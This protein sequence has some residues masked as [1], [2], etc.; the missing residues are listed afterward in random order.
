M[1]RRP[2]V[3]V[4]WEHNL[5]FREGRGFTWL[6]TRPPPQGEWSSQSFPANVSVGGAQEKDGSVQ[7]AAFWAKATAQSKFRDSQPL[8]PHRSGKTHLRGLF[9]PIRPHVYIFAAALAAHR[10]RLE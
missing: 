7:V 1:A 3:F 8:A 2:A 9:L 10:A 4:I 5:K 6:G